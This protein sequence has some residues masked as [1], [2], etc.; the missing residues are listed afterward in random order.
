MKC[1]YCEK[2]ERKIY[3]DEVCIGF[4]NDKPSAPGHVILIPKEHFTILEQVPESIVG[5]LFNIS[6]Q[7]SSILFEVLEAQGTNVIVQN[8]IGAGQTQAHV[9][10]HIIPRKENDG[11]NFQWKPK[12]L[13]E[14]EKGVVELKL[15]KSCSGIITGGEVTSKEIKVQEVEKPEKTEWIEKA[16]FRI[17]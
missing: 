12:E 16:L 4:L 10:L 5:H 13:S 8:G 1:N 14:E 17:P 2:I 15:K 11:L 7:L 3:E 6:N 9:S